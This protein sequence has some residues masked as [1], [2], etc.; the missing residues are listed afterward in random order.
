[1][2]ILH[3]FYSLT[4][5]VWI[6]CII[7]IMEQRANLIYIDAAET[8]NNISTADTRNKDKKTG[9]CFFV[10][11]IIVIIMLEIFSVKNKKVSRVNR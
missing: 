4:L 1:M 5:I 3:A 11:I 2:L 8:S 7:E 6:M 9:N 10:K